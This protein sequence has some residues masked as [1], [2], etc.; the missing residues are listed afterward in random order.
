[1]D[2]SQ[3]DAIGPLGCFRFGLSGGLNKV[4]RVL[5]G[6]RKMRFGLSG[7]GASG[8]DMRGP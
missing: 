2:G 3:S 7:L 5:G 1:M 6:F 4:T 8:A